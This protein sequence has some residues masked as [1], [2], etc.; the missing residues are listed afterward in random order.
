MFNIRVV[1][2]ETPNNDTE[3]V[4]NSSKEF[5]LT[6]KRQVVVFFLFTVD[7]TVMIDQLSR[8]PTDPHSESCQ[9]YACLA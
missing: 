7:V 8:P 3:I 1:I 5:F 4:T 2:S 9:L 6:V